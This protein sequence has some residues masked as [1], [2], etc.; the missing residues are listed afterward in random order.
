VKSRFLPFVFLFAGVAARGGGPAVSDWVDPRAALSRSTAPLSLAEGL[1]DAQEFEAVTVHRDALT[2]SGKNEGANRLRLLEE[3]Y[4]GNDAGARQALELIEK[5]DP[6]VHARRVYIEGVMERRGAF[7]ETADDRFIFRTPEAD[8]FLVSYARPALEGAQARL[9]EV[10]PSTGGLPVVIEIYPSVDDYVFAAGIPKE[11]VFRAGSIAT[12]RFNRVMALSPG[13]PAQGYRWI[14]ALVHE[15]AHRHIRRASGGLCPPWLSEGLARYFEVAWR[16]PDGFRHTPYA[17]ALLTRA[18][19]D[20]GLI[21]FSRL[22]AGYWNLESAERVDLAFAQTSDAVG[23]LIKEFGIEKVSALV[24]SFRRWSRADAFG[25]ILGSNEA[26]VEKAWRDSLADL[27]ET[28]IGTA[29]G[30]MGPVVM[31]GDFDETVLAGPAAQEFLRAGDRL[32]SQGGAAAAAAQYKKAV[33]T[34]PDNGVALTRLARAHLRSD[35]AGAAEELLKRAAEMNP[36]YAAPLV[37]LGEMYYDDGRYEEGQEVL[38]QALEIRPF[39]A[40]IH[41]ALGRI[42]MDM[43][44]TPAARQS[45]RLALRFDPTNKDVR[46]ALSGMRD[47]R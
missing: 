3:L 14:D 30:A 1:L 21:P 42:A 6:W 35:R 7:K 4:A 2:A 29:R 33:E 26:E 27:T 40:P 41:A 13:V 44:Y 20:D 28:P 9:A 45:Y 19:L 24:A 8:A 15:L 23:F 22:E 46:D 34:A 31:A 43:G 37:A 47:R 18:A 5:K 36:D 11:K 39:Y 38:Q 16:R 10:F 25:Q 32:L 12:G 17:R